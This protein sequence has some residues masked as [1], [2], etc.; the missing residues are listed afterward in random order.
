MVKFLTKL[1][2]GVFTWYRYKLHSGTKSNFVPRLHGSHFT[3]ITRSFLWALALTSHFRAL[4]TIDTHSLPIPVNSVPP[5]YDTG[6]ECGQIS[7]RYE[8]F[9]PVS[10]KRIQSYKWEPGWTRT[11]MKLVP[12]SCK[13]SLTLSSWIDSAEINKCLS[14]TG[15]LKTWKTVLAA[16]NY[17]QPQLFQFLVNS[18]DPKNKAWRRCY[19]RQSFVQRVSQC[20]K[21]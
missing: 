19:T 5:L 14:A 3:R 6:T 8:R 20:L 21:A 18:V 13:H 7:Y 10:C 11:G 2:Q 16:N 1:N 9:V 4:L 17:I 15:Y 12:V